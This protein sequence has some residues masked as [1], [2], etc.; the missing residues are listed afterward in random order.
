[1]FSGRRRLSEPIATLVRSRRGFN[2]EKLVTINGFISSDSLLRQVLNSNKSMVV[3]RSTL[4]LALGTMPIWWI[5]LRSGLSRGKRSAALKTAFN[6]TAQVAP[7]ALQEVKWQWEL[8]EDSTKSVV[9][10]AM[11][12]ADALH[13]RLSP[14]SP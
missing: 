5:S 6:L 13:V 10:M 11:S 4:E 3:T 7:M 1:M 8:K 2:L 14:D 12:G 9:Y